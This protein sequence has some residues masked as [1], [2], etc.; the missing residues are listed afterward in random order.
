M[1]MGTKTIA[2]VIILSSCT[3]TVVNY[4]SVCPGNDLK[5]QRNLDAQTLS[6]IGEDKAAI[7]LMCLDPDLSDLLGSDC[8]R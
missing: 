5:C 4:P 1:K 2:L 8:L 6:I 3:T 7:K